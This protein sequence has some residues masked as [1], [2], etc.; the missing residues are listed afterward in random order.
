MCGGGLH[1]CCLNS[2]RLVPVLMSDVI[3]GRPCE[4]RELVA[5]SSV[6]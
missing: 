4:V 3:R 1:C 5:D 2:Y 6:M